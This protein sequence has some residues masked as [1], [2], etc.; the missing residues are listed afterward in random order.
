MR[1][2]IWTCLL[3]L[4]LTATGCQSPADLGGR[5]QQLALSPSPSTDRAD[6]EAVAAENLPA[7]ELPASPQSDEE[8]RQ[9]RSLDEL[10]L[11]HPTPY[12][13][14]DW[15][16]PELRFED[17]WMVS[18]DG[19]KLH[20][21]YCPVGQPRAH[22][23]FL[24][25]NAGNV[26]GWSQ[27]A[28]LLQEKLKVTTLLLDYRGFGRSEG[29]PTVDGVLAD[30]RAARAELARLG[31]V[32]ESQVVLMGRSLGGAVAIQLAAEKSPRGLI[33]ESSFSSLK[34]A[35]HVHFPGLSWMVPKDRLDS[36][37]AMSK[38]KGPLLLSHGDAD[39]VIP[40]THG[41]ALFSAAA[42]PKQ[43][44]RIPGGGHND[45]PPVEYVLQL[46]QFI[47]GLK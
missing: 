34:S 46:N 37:S 32:D 4:G 1:C 12:P 31:D 17:A 15:N 10:L 30:A 24:H 41:E 7:L 45:P 3:L 8:I 5:L 11:F 14:G 25:G 2:P 44:I 9:R 21:W 22:V 35:A 20:G 16:P 27:Y 18:A 38:F 13:H 26:A 28:R 33:V 40:F 23:L 43:F 47:V 36:V 39:Q 42:E 29:K 6:S 19:K